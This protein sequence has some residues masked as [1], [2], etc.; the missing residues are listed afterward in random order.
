MF[1][2]SY[3]ILSNISEMPKKLKYAPT[4]VIRWIV[5]PSMEAPFGCQEQNLDLELL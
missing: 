4:T 2:V 5:H 3:A 1:M